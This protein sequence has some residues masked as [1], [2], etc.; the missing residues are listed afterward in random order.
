MIA[1]SRFLTRN[2]SPLTPTTER[3]LNFDLQRHLMVE[4]QLV[5]R[6]IRD[7]RVLAAM[8]KVAR[9]LFVP[10]ELQKRAYRDSALPIANGQTIS[11]PYMVALMSE[12]LGLQGQEAVLEIGTGSGYQSAVLGELAQQVY[13]IERHE[14]LAKEALQILRSIGYNNIEV[15]VANG[16]RGWDEAA[17]YEAILVTA[18]SPN[19][20]TALLEQLADSGRLV[21][22]I[23]SPRRQVLTKIVRHGNRFQSE[24]LTACVFVPLVDD[25][26]CLD[27][28]QP[29][30]RRG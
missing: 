8:Q 15:I 28:S 10:P 2:P 30:S 14:T 6:G 18:G 24:D 29:T 12:A 5:S 27:G 25:Y 20:P 21:I 22:P 4:E 13:S 7:R 23:G 19:L 3:D 11:Q 9:H 17:P 1:L 16:V 26:H